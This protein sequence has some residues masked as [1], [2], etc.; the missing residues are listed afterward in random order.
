MAIFLFKYRCQSKVRDYTGTT[1]KRAVN[2]RTVV[3]RQVADQKPGSMLQIENIVTY[4][5][6]QGLRFYS[7][8]LARGTQ[9]HLVRKMEHENIR[10]SIVIKE[11]TKPEIFL[12]SILHFQTYHTFCLHL[13]VLFFDGHKVDISVELPFNKFFSFVRIM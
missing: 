6:E 4:S 10:G 11:I 1:L 7:D 5:I 13:I 12:R 9:L 2:V 3:Y 8:I